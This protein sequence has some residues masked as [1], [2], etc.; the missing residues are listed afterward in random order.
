MF[1]KLLKKDADKPNTP[2]SSQRK[3]SF[4]DGNEEAQGF[5]CPQCMKNLSSADA[6]QKHFETEH[7]VQQ[8]NS[9][10]EGFLCPICK[11]SLPSPEALQAHYD[12]THEQKITE[13]RDG[14]VFALRQEIDELR[15]MLNDEKK[16]GNKSGSLSGED[17]NE[18]EMM[19]L[20]LKGSEESRT[21]LGSEVHHLQAKIAE[22]SGQIDVLREEKEKYQIKAAS[23]ASE[24]VNSRARADEAEA[25]KKAL[26]DHIVTLK[27]QMET[28]EM[29]VKSIESQLS[30]RPGSEDVLVLKQELISVQT[31]MD[32]V[33]LETEKEKE[34]LQREHNELKKKHDFSE[35][36]I[37]KLEA[38]LA[39]APRPEDLVRSEEKIKR[40]EGIVKSSKN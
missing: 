21:L 22:Q 10:E 30:Q 35:E 38:Q 29:Y 13:N 6:L 24:S 40:L 39:E 19:R 3:P 28:R 17:K 31:L 20:Q 12:S 9:S 27:Q 23:L 16:R 33:A 18:L 2:S 8:S 25:Q 5:L 37:A 11:I 26:E 7:N 14:D 15:R 32:K 34:A 1:R 4:Q 36:K